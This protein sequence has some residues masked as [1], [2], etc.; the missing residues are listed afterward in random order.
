MSLSFFDRKY[1]VNLVRSKN[2]LMILGITMTDTVEN[3][4]IEEFILNLKGRRGY[5]E[6]R[7]LNKVFQIL[8]TI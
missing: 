2:V 6:K 8:K 7:R 3:S 1:H 5:E 4:Q